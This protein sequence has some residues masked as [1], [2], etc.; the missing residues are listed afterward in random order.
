MQLTEVQ[1][2]KLLR[3][4]SAVSA[5]VKPCA[6]CGKVEWELSDRIYELREFSGGGLLV[7][8]SIYPVIAMTCRVCGT[9]VLL[10]AIVLGLIDREAPVPQTTPAEQSK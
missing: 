6:L 1:K 10:N 5:S 9:A 3:R 7:G 8:G 2:E 4:L